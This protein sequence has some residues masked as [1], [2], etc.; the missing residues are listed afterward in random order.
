MDEWPEF[1]ALPY[2]RNDYPQWPHRT[3]FAIDLPNLCSD[4][5]DLLDVSPSFPF[6]SSAPTITL[7]FS[8]LQQI[9]QYD[10]SKRI[11][12]VS[13]LRHAFCY[14][15]QSPTRIPA[16][17]VSPSMT[18]SRPTPV[19]LTDLTPREEA[20]EEKTDI[21]LP[22][23]SSLPSSQTSFDQESAGKASNLSMDPNPI[24]ELPMRRRSPRGNPSPPAS[25]TAAI[26]EPE[27]PQPLKR[28]RR[29]K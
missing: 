18:P 8:S 9:F 6:S 11:P 1:P 20:G 4:G 17:P 22:H 21:S 13:A 19:P 27:P 16:T 2:A 28:H 15:A 7:L 26:E 14:K 3:S 12:A 10:A 25:S 23:P 5:I 24:T 29:K